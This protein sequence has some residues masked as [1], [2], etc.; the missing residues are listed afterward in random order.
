MLMTKRYSV[1]VYISADV[2]NEIRYSE[3]FIYLFDKLNELF[4]GLWLYIATCVILMLLI[5]LSAIETQFYF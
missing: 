1:N 5:L 3:K 2:E 4:C